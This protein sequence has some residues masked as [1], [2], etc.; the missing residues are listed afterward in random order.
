MALF[1]WQTTLS[2]RHL[3]RKFH[4]M[5]VSLPA[6]AVPSHVVYIY[7]FAAREFGKLRINHG[8]RDARGAA[9]AKP[10]CAL[11]PVLHAARC[12]FIH[13]RI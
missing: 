2:K 12:K 9:R 5:F 8:R 3:D 1:I 10:F 4:G 13:A 11:S 6:T 7:S